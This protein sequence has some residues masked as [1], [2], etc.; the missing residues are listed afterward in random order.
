M[1]DEPDVGDARWDARQE[2]LGIPSSV[3][4]LEMHEIVFMEHFTRDLSQHFVWIPK[5]EENLRP[6]NDFY[7]IEQQTEVELKSTPA[8]TPKYHSEANKIRIAVKKSLESDDR[9]NRAQKESFVLDYYG[10]RLTRKLL[11]QLST[12]NSRNPLYAV[13]Q[14]W[15]ANES[16]IHKL[17]ML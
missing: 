17:T 7:W 9:G 2:A 3:D 13:K 12:Y 14:L 15:Y 5:D 11:Y 8:I 6:T 10:T 1:R 4:I 16:G